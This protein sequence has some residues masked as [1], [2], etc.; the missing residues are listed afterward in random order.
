[1]CRKNHL[2]QLSD[3]QRWGNGPRTE[4]VTGWPNEITSW[5]I[6]G[7][8]LIAAFLGPGMFP[9]FFHHPVIT[10]SVPPGLACCS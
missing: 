9:T 10:V 7:H 6:L 3:L 1:M 5:M 2:V 4:E 8:S